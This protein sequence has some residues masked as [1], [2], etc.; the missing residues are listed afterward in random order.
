MEEMKIDQ[1]MVVEAEVDILVKT[2]DSLVSL[3]V[4]AS[5]GHIDG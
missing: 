1:Y 2:R 3:Y 5:R 4:I